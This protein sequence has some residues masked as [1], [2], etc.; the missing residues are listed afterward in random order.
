M[1]GAPGA[2]K[3]RGD[4][5][6]RKASI[7][8]FNALPR[9][10]PLVGGYL[11]AFAH[12]DPALR[13]TWDIELYNDHVKTPASQ[14][15]QHLVRHQPEVIGFSVYTWNVG[16]VQRVL[17]TLRGLLPPTTR[18][19]LGGV[20]VMHCGERYVEPAWENVA[21]CNGEGEHTFAEFL[22]H[23]DSPS[24]PL[25]AVKGL[26]FY[27]DRQ[28]ITTEARPRVNSLDELPSPYLTGAIPMEGIDVATIETNR[29]CPFACEY[30]FWGGAIGQKIHKA[31]IERIKEEITELA[32]Q[33]MRVLYIVDANFGILP[34]DVDIAEH[35]VA[36][37]EKYRAPNHIIFSSSKNTSDR[38]EQVSRIFAKAGLLATQ[39]ISLQSTDAR[40]LAIAKRDSIKQETY[41]RLQRRLNEWGVPSHIELMWPLPGETLDSFKNGLDYLCANGAQAFN[42][43]PLLWLNNVGYRERREELGVVTLKEDDPTSGGEMVI[44]TNE[45]SYREYIDG[46]L[47]ASALYLLHDCRGLYLTTRL[48]HTLGL[49]RLRDVVDEFAGW[50]SQASGG[51]L[52][53]S[54]RD[55][56][57]HFEQ[58]N[59]F[60][61]RGAL[62]HTMLHAQRQ[63]FDRLVKTFADERLERVIGPL[64]PHDML[65]RGAVEFD[66]LNRPYVYLQTPLQVGVG[67]EVLQI[68]EQ[69]RG[70]WVVESPFDYAAMVTA[71]R[72]EGTIGAQHVQAGAVEITID[73]RAHQLF[74]P[75]TRSEEQLHWHSMRVIDAMRH[76]EAR[77]QS[78]QIAEPLLGA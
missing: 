35:I 36:M 47:F 7:I 69:R 9:V 11:K 40:T 45:V 65:I 27:R 66:L 2:L 10:A 15:I 24:S 20:E 72:T 37:K 22:R 57:V 54:W 78:R 67:L 51:T 8:Q 76:S 12:A 14:L 75:D 50:L 39:P 52:T 73:H 16:L 30:C 70:V 63:E 29:G 32:K 43:Y 21:V 18:Y 49:T 33:R 60:V 68:K 13:D 58:I 55:G 77:Y 74:L 46:L 53:D 19:L 1:V 48:L 34:R 41:L 64:G 28:W 42:V 38:V 31:G 6:Q 62:A 4:I 17:P 26:S 25:D 61:W 3:G 56:M 5:M 71:L 23:V 59:K 44:Q